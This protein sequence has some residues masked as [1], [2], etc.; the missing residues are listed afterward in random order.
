[1]NFKALR[2]RQNLS[3]RQAADKLGLNFQSICRYENKGRVP[4]K[5][6]LI[7][8]LSVYNCTERELG[9]AV[10]HNIKFGREKDETKN[11]RT[12]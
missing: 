9:E 1:M 8:M 11:I 4:K 10:S 3:I 7:K 5:Q 6:I 12:N 2:K